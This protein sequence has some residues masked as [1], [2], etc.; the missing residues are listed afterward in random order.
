[1]KTLLTIFSITIFSICNLSAQAK[2]GLASKNRITTEEEYNYMTK[3]YQVQISSGLD[4]KKGYEFDTEVPITISSYT[5]TYMPLLKINQQT[6]ENVGLM[7]KAYSTVSGRTYY[8]CIPTGND[9][10]ISQSFAHITE[11]DEAMTTSFFK[12]Y[13]LFQNKLY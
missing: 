7:V 1:M 4:M 11:L 2:L 13:I 8:F 6:K 3:G 10:L 12:S 5:F 9:A